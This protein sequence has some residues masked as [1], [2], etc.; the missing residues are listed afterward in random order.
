MKPVKINTLLLYACL[1]PLLYALLL[2]CYQAFDWST[3]TGYPI[4]FSRINSYIYAHSYG[5]LLL[6]LLVGIQ[7]G[8]SL[9]NKPPNAEI[10]LYLSVALS[11]WI[12]MRSFAD[13]QGVLMLMLGYSTLW[14]FQLVTTSKPTSTEAFAR[15]RIIISPIIL[16]LLLALI[17]I[18]N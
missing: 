6:V 4:P 15:F 18:N 9:H 5:A 17:L 8:Q 10:I 12:S 3:L 14:F 11:T 13:M 7:I 16:L 2:A 1:L